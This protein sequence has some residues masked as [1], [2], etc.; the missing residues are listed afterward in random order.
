M[1]LPGPMTSDFSKM[2]FSLERQT[3]LLKTISSTVN[4]EYHFFDRKMATAMPT[5]AN[6]ARSCRSITLSVRYLLAPS[7]GSTP[8][9]LSP[10]PCDFQKTL[11]R[12]EPAQKTLCRVGIDVPIVSQSLLLK[13]CPPPP[14]RNHIFAN[15]CRGL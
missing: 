10:P 11:A 14:H 6:F 15:R 13:K 4:K 5:F 2:C 12:A 1:V 9:H 8:V 7:C 3:H